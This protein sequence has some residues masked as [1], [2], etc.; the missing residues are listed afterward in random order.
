LPHLPNGHQIVLSDLGHA[1][2]FWPYQPA[3]S[4]KLMIVLEVAGIG[5]RP[6]TVPSIAVPSAEH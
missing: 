2:D 1:D 4:T 3:A 5:E 6:E